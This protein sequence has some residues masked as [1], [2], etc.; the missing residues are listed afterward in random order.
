VQNILVANTVPSC[1]V[2]PSTTWRR[3]TWQ[4]FTTATV[5][6]LTEGTT[7][8]YRVTASYGSTPAGNLGGYSPLPPD[9][10]RRLYSCGRFA[11]TPASP[12]HP[13]AGGAQMPAT[14]HHTPRSPDASLWLSPNQAASRIRML[15]AHEF[16]V[17]INTG[18]DGG[19]KIFDLL[20]TCGPDGANL[21][22]R[23]I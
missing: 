9:L 17:A 20:L 19:I 5:C 15:L 6:N 7:Y 14:M 18:T 11:V 4:R 8:D 21:A 10:S 12:L 23:C 22:K 2:A 16:S 3:S 1:S 13:M